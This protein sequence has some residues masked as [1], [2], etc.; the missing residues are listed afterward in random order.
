MD[1]T[2]PVPNPERT[3]GLRP[4]VGVPPG[5]TPPAEDGLS[6][7]GPQETYNPTKGW[8][9]G[10]TIIIWAFVV[11]FAAFCVAFAIVVL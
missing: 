10:P 4:S 7:T 8:S 11:L 3:P 2:N 6:E 5:E 1:Q 9:K